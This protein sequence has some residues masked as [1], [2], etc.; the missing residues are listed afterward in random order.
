MYCLEILATSRDPLH[1]LL[2]LKISRGE[3]NIFVSLWYLNI[4]FDITRRKRTVTSLCVRQH[5]MHNVAVTSAEYIQWV[6]GV[7]NYIHQW[8]IITINFHLSLKD[9]QLLLEY[10][11]QQIPSI[12]LGSEIEFLISFSPLKL[13]IH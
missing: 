7:M 3:W 2:L 13:E 4:G 6:F 1:S 11:L 9:K 5:N 8:T 10:F 12:F